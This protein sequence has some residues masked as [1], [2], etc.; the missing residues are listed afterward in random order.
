MFL[1]RTAEHSFTKTVNLEIEGPIEV[2]FGKDGKH[3]KK[4]DSLHHFARELA[5]KQLRLDGKEEWNGLFVAVPD[6]NLNSY[7]YCHPFSL[8]NS[9]TR[10]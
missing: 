10:V 1:F 6:L 9:N 8:L 7:F 2:H 4:A 5:S 3:T